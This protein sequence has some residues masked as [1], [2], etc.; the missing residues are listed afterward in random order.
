MKYC[1]SSMVSSIFYNYA[2][3]AKLPQYVRLCV[4]PETAAHQTPLSLGFSRQEHWNGLPCPSPEDLPNPRIEP[5][6][7]V[8]PEL[9]VDSL[10]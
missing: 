6:S 8:S 2:A 4:T 9:Q 1:S 3:A 5:M 10:H 7:P